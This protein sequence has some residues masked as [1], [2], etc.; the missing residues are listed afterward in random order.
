MWTEAKRYNKYHKYANAKKT[1]TLVSVTD[2]DRR[3]FVFDQ[4]VL[5]TFK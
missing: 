4:T 2:N 1:N 3:D 5:F